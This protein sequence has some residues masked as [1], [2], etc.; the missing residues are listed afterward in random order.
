MIPTYKKEEEEF[1]AEYRMH[2]NGILREDYVEGGIGW[3]LGFLR[4]THINLLSK[5]IEELEGRKNNFHLLAEDG[6]GEGYDEAIDTQIK[7][8]EELKEYIE[9]L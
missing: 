2:Y 6:F 4:K 8:L 3:H 9:G 1:E 5:Q 7:K